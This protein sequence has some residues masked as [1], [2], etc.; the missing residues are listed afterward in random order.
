MLFIEIL[1]SK[2]IVNVV[3]N[4]IAGIAKLRR[5]AGIAC[6]NLTSRRCDTGEACYSLEQRCDGVAQCKDL[7]DEHN[8]TG[9]WTAPVY[10]YVRVTLDKAPTWC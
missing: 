6:D 10:D 3:A 1:C 4:R 9:E 7:S 8:C 2:V 5:F